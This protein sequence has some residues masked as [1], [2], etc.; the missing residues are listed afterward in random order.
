MIRIIV[1]TAPIDV[2]AE[3]TQAETAGERGAGAVATFTGL[4]RADDGV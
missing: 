1:Q 2:L 4:V 3:I